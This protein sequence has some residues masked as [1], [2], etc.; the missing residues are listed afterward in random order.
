[1]IDLWLRDPRKYLRLALAE[2]FRKFTWHFPVAF[3]KRIELMSSLRLESIGYTGVQL[4]IVDDSGSAEYSVFSDY[5]KPTAV[6]PTWNAREDDPDQLIWLAENYVGGNLLMCT[7]ESVDVHMRPVLGQKHRVVIHRLPQVLSEEF[8]STLEFL[9]HAVQDYP[10]CEFFVSGLD[11]FSYVFGMGFQAVDIR[12][13]SVMDTGGYG[14]IIVLPTG[15]QLKSGVSYEFDKRYADWFALVGWNQAQLVDVEDYTRYNLTAINW[16]S[17]YYSTITPFTW[18]KSRDRKLPIGLATIDDKSFVLPAAR[19]RLMRN[20]GMMANEADKFKCDACILHN[21]CMLYREGS[22]CVVMGSDGLDIAHQFGTR[23]VDSIIGALG[24]LV[25]RQAERLQDAQA[26]EDV[27][28]ELDPEVTK[29]YKTVFDQGVKLAKL[30]DPNLNGS[31]VQV[32]VGVQGNA[33]V[34]VASSDPRQM[35]ATIMAEFESSGFRRDEI[36]SDMI[37][38]ALTAMAGD[39][40]MQQ[41]VQTVKATREIEGK[42]V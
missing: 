37:K 13:K 27:S 21:T 38:G 10:D 16:A 24:K 5:D 28:G 6:Y 3:N 20:L 12:P 18:S 42:V 4:M 17:R 40:S 7:D 30:I 15:K 19:R 33:A 22:V 26:A 1:M 32:N 14:K 31:K 9:R 36:T 2:G 35:V 29:M 8:K 23:N 41:A 25:E 39:K 34:Q 11:N